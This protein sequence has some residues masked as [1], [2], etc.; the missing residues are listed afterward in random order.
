MPPSPS[1][2]KPT[3]KRD[4]RDPQGRQR[5]ACRACG[6]DFMERSVSA[7]AGYRWPEEVIL[8]AV[9]WSLSH[10]LSATSVMELL[11]ER[12]VDVSKRTVLRWVQTFGPLLAAEARKQRRRPGRTWCVDAVFFFRGGGKERRYQSRAVD[13]HGQVLDVLFRDHRGT[14]SAEAFFRRMPATSGVAPT[15]VVSD[16]QQP[17]GKAVQEVSPAATHVRTGLY[18]A[19][20]ETTKCVERSHIPPDQTRDR[21]RAVVTAVSVPGARLCRA[22]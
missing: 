14:A 9:R 13:E 1:C 4:G 22:I 12:G 6:R 2:H 7:F 15:T 16:H 3:T 11:A 8:L 20:G 10:P 18:W 17:Y 5:Y 19:Q 21:A